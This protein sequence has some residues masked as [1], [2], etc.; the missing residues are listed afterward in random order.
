MDYPFAY[1]VSVDPEG[2][3]IA[4]AVAEGKDQGI[5]LLDFKTGKVTK[6][7]P[8]EGVP[9]C[10]AF[11]RDWKLC[12]VGTRTVLRVWETSTGKEI[13]K[14]EERRSPMAMAFT[15][16]G[17]GL[18]VAAPDG[19]GPIRRLELPTGKE[20][21]SYNAV[22]G[23]D[24]CLS[25]SPDGKVL[26]TGGPGIRGLGVLELLEPERAASRWVK[27]VNSHHVTAVQFSPT[28]NILATPVKDNTIRLWK[29]TIGN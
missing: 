10:V 7:L 2:K 18:E 15:P 5:D 20:V 17:K 19:Y 12:A 4:V 28:E 6:H 1:Q 21:A 11:S 24:D 26:A 14:L 29:V 27:D 25:Y 22:C 16:D 13:T 23:A 9:Y 8:C 3:I